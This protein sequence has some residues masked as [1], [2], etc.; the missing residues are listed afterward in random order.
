MP[1]IVW[2]SVCV[3]VSVCLEHISSFITAAM[4]E[5]LELLWN[6]LQQGRFIYLALRLTEGKIYY[7]FNDKSVR[8]DD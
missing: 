1:K 5:I 8:G 3:C 7:D 2:T 6:I 4:G